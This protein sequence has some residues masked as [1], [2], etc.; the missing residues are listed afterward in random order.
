MPDGYDPDT[1][2]LKYAVKND[3]SIV[4]QIKAL[5]NQSKILKP[6]EVEKPTYIPM[7]KVENIY[8]RERVDVEKLVSGINIKD[9]ILQSGVA[10]RKGG[11]NWNASCPFHSEKTASFM[12]SEEKQ[13]FK[14][15]GCGKGGNVIKFLELRNNWTFIETINY[16]RSL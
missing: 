11:R 5:L 12:V 8:T 16:L 4:V 1:F 2:A 10:L 3:N 14:C 9:I 13:L 6:T 7:E 15:F